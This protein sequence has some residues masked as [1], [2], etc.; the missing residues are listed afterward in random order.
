[1]QYIKNNKILF[2]KWIVK[3][4][5]KLKWKYIKNVKWMNVKMLDNEWIIKLI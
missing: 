2:K 4:M 1:M 5:H 3:L